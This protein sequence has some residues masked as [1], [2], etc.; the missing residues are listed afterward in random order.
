VNSSSLRVRGTR[1]AAGAIAR[2]MRA[3]FPVGLVSMLGVFSVGCSAPDPGVGDPNAVRHT[4]SSS[5][6]SGGSSGG[7]GGQLGSSGSGSSSGGTSSGVSGSSSGGGSSSSGAS[8]SSSGSGSGGSS[9]GGEDDAGASSSSGGG[10]GGGEAGGAGAFGA[11][12]QQNSD[13][14]SND[15]QV[16]QG[17][18]G[19]FCTQPCQT[20]ADCPNPPNLGCNNMGQCKVP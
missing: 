10:S 12:C 19:S 7:N 1:G 3:A 15:C 16:F 5:S 14:A 6:G 20:A 4:T 9:S 2:A 18:G 17:K 13:C 8:G 11:T